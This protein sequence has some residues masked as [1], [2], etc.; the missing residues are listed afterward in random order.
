MI[1]YDE[2]NH[3][4]FELENNINPNHQHNHPLTN[5][6]ILQQINNQTES[7]L[8]LDSHKNPGLLLPTKTR[9][10]LIKLLIF[11]II[12]IFTATQVYFND[13]LVKNINQTNHILR[14][15][16]TNLYFPEPNYYQS[17]FFQDESARLYQH[18]ENVFRG[19][20]N[21]IL[22][23]QKK[24]SKY[25]N[26]LPSHFQKYHFLDIGFGR[27]EFLQILKNSHINHITGVDTNE[28]FVS[29]AS[30]KGFNVYN[31]DGLTFL[32]NTSDSFCGISLFHLLEHLIFPEIF[33]LLRLI[34]NKLIKNGI[35]ILETP[36]PENLQVSSYSF[37]YD[38]THKTK[39][40]PQFLKSILLFIGFRK[41]KIL[42]ASP[43]KEKTTTQI[44]SLVNGAREY[45][46]IAYK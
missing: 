29:Q 17:V 46:I 31:Q 22:E 14:D 21:D 35:L 36:N 27:G 26:K 6:N 40:P 13:L 30:K 37:Y 2:P 41:V 33:D 28:V 45:A 11:K 9:F 25:L 1:F 7:I 4:I 44:D 24:Y 43:F 3:D 18:L 12:K 38:Y 34:H 19:S 5:N 15:I 10:R 32:K 42:Y 20:E 23:R 16:A 39:L 8:L